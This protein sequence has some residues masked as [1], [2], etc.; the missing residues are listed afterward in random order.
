MQNSLSINSLR[1][2]YLKR[3]FAPREYIAMCREKIQLQNQTNPAWIYQLSDQELEPYL[4][5]LEEQ[6]PERLPLFGIPFAI[7]DNIDLAG[8]PTTAGCP[9]FSYMPKRSAYVVERLIQAGAI[10]LGKTNLDQFATGL[11]GARSPWGACG[12][13]FDQEYVSGGSSAGS[14]VSVAEGQV[15]FSLGT[16][17]AG[18]GRIPAAFNNLVGLKPSRGLLSNTGMVRACRSLDCISIFALT[19]LDAELVLDIAADYDSG[20]EYSRKYQPCTIKN[21]EQPRVAIPRND[22][23]EFFGDA[24]YID[25]HKEALE[26]ATKFGWELVE[27]DFSQLFRAAKMLYEG[28][29]VAERNAAYGDFAKKNPDSVLPVIHQILAPAESI[30]ATQNFECQ[31][32]MQKIMLDSVTLLLSVLYTCKHAKIPN[33]GPLNVHLGVFGLPIVSP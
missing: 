11:V 19:A 32:E 5:K 18:S 15:M 13:V 25:C 31:Y 10:P 16:D 2:Q 3:E 33:D 14:A 24:E 8:I 27:T 22:Q 7:K 28:P 9:D 21:I 6:T 30:S 17:T 23:L 4:L 29:W 12:S 26:A 20:D 1:K